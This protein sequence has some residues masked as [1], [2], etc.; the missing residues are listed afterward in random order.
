MSGPF[1]RKHWDTL[2]SCESCVL[3]RELTR[4]AEEVD[5]LVAMGATAQTI[6]KT[7]RN[8]IPKRLK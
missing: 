5:R 3:E 1:C 7:I 4:L 2:E 6:A 8:R